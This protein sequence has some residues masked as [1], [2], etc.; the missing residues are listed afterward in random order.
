[1]LITRARCKEKAVLETSKRNSLGGSVAF[2][3]RC[4]PGAYAKCSKSCQENGSWWSLVSGIDKSTCAKKPTAAE[5]HE[6][7][8][9]LHIHAQHAKNLYC[10]ITR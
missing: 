5:T 2:N 10:C 9:A 8:R 7:Y 4:L 3:P 6:K 1:M